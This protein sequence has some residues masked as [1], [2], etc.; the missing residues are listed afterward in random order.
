M[1]KFVTMALAIFISSAVFANSQEMFKIDETVMNTELQELYQL[2]NYLVGKDLTFSS[3][4]DEDY[5]LSKNII[6]TTNGLHTIMGLSEP[7]LGISSFLWGF[8]LGI[9]G[10]AIVYFVSE[11]SAETRKALWGCVAGGLLYTVV[12]VGYYALVIGFSSSL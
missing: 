9:P 2:E 12:Y 10:I 8:C 11:D 1:K 7:P 4:A 6:G 3:L 5:F